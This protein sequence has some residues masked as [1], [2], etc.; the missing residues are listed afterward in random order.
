MI[1][2]KIFTELQNRGIIT[3]VGLKAEDYKNLDELKNYG[4]A[5]SIA[6]EE[7]YTDIVND[8]N[9]LDTFL[10][11]VK[12]GGLVT[13]DG[14]I[15]LNDCIEI[16]NE[17]TIDLNGK[18][19]TNAVENTTTDVIVVEEGA[20]LT[21]NGD[22]NITAV[23]GNDGYAIISNG[24]VIINGGNYTSGKDE[25]NEFNAV[26][27]ARGNGKVY[28]NGGT[29]Q[30]EG[31]AGTFILNKKDADRAT[32]EIVVKGG[33]FANFNPANNAAEGP[34]T[35]FVADG[36]ES[37]LEGDYYIVKEVEDIVVDDNK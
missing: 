27:Y 10:A 6:T 37:V 14:D 36:Y 9:Y 3:N 17:V 35:N 16:R 20:T 11:A 8:I 15:I 32:T 24:T 22:G 2:E 4:L 34:N 31:G 5:T 25:N 23:S 29:F 13:L 30:N 19:I 28:I 12:A 18:T 21:I 33:S 7:V 26:I 1:D